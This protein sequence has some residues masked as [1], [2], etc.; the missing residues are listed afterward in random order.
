MGG[1]IF[2]HGRKMTS[3]T[4]FTSMAMIHHRRMKT[5]RYRIKITIKPDGT[6]EII[7]EP[8]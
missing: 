3:A 1:S 7:I 5:P 2:C 6:I 8:L 4:W